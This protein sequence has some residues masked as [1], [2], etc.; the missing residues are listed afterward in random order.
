MNI[1]AIHTTC[2]THR[3]STM[4]IGS[5]YLFGTSHIIVLLL[6]RFCTHSHY[7]TS[8][9]IHINLLRFATHNIL[10]QFSNICGIGSQANRQGNKT[11]IARTYFLNSKK[12][13]FEC[14]S[15]DHHNTSV[16]LQ[17]LIMVNLD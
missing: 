15:F 12:Q 16:T 13:T 5:Y 8:N 14:S 7:I 17:A 1:K 6:Y 4:Q 2:Y 3:H 11:N 10:S 9:I